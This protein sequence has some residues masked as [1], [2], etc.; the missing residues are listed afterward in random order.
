[1]YCSCRRTHIL[2]LLLPQVTVFDFA[3]ILERTERRV[4]DDLLGA[5]PKSVDELQAIAARLRV[6]YQ[7]QLDRRL[8]KALQQQQSME[9]DGGD[10][11]AAAAPAV[12]PVTAAKSPPPLKDVMDK[13]GGAAGAVAASAGAA[14]ASAGA[15]AGGLFAKVKSTGAALGTNLRTPTSASAAAAGAGPS[16]TIVDLPPPAPTSGGT[17]GDWADIA[18]ATD[19][20]SNFSIGDEEEDDFL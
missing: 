3:T 7:T 16:A 15:F 14:A 8:Q 19:A 12:T 2:T 10:K 18:P 5:G 13:A 20:I 6:K 17:D 11:K 4:R 1:M 9:S